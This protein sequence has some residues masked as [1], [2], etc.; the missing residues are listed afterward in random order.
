MNWSLVSLWHILTG[1]LA[2]VAFCRGCWLLANGNLIGFLVCS[3]L[4]ALMLTSSHHAARVCIANA[5]D[6]A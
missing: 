4:T 1:S 6:P 5:A 2:V 3:A